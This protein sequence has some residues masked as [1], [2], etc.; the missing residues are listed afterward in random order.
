MQTCAQISIIQFGIFD[1]IRTSLVSIS[2]SD[3]VVIKVQTHMELNQ[4]FIGTGD[5]YISS[6]FIDNG[7]INITILINFVIIRDN[8]SLAQQIVKIKVLSDFDDSREKVILTVVA[9]I[10][11]PASAMLLPFMLMERFSK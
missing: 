11:F 7:I 6:N 4:I 1:L 3:I 5:L 2:A 9:N 10:I 8:T